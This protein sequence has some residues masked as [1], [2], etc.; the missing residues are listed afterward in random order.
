MLSNVHERNF[1]AE[2]LI[3]LLV[4]YSILILKFICFFDENVIY[5]QYKRLKVLLFHLEAHSTYINKSNHIST[6]KLFVLYSQ[7]LDFLNSDIIVRL[8]AESTQDASRFI[9]N[10][11]NNYDEL[12]RTVKEALVLIECISSFELDPM[13]ASLTLIIINFILEL[14]NILECSIKKFKSLNK[15]NFQKLFE[16]RKK[17]IDK[18]D[19]SMRI[20]SQ[21]LENYQESVDNYKKNRHR[22]EEYKK[23]LEGSSCE[24]DSKD[25][26]STKQLFENYYNNNEC[27]ELQ[28]F[29]MEIL[30]LISIEMLGLIGFNVFY[31][32]TMKI[33]KLIATIEG[34]QIKAN[35]ETQK[36]GTEASVSEEDALNIRE[37]VMEKLGYDK[38]VSLDIISSKFRKQLDSKVI[39]SNIKGLYLLLI[40]MLQLLK[41]ELQLNK[42]G[43]YI[44]KLLELTISVFDSISMECLFSIKSYEKLGDIAIIPLETIR[45]EREATVQKLK[46]IFSLQI[47]QTK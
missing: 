32:D 41:R 39:L 11:A 10:F 20:S 15:T 47:E 46:E 25:I 2:L 26:E 38:I 40:K 35:E 18:I 37:A 30:I 8:N 22:I 3:K 17:L 27:T 29:E 14:I 16:S 13:L 45:T 42:C 31:F 9:T 43:A 44:Q 7:C 4:S 5:E 1:V 12:L 36:R 28:I 19:V 33:R 21:R 34:L 24:L 23:F 6:E